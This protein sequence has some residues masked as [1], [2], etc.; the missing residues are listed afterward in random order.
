MQT[1][2]IFNHETVQLDGERFSDCEFKNCRLVYRGGEPPKFDNCKFDDVDWRF[3]D[4]AA[5]TMAHMKTVWMSGGKAPVQALIK[6]ITAA[7]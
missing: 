6:T 4:A 2:T 7:S 1:A 5:R 3:E